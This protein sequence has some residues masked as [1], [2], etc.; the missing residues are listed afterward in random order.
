ME[1]VAVTLWLCLAVCTRGRIT[2]YVVHDGERAEADTP[3]T[4]SAH[5]SPPDPASDRRAPS[6]AAC[7]QASAHAALLALAPVIHYTARVTEGS[8]AQKP[9]QK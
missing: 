8:Q 7:P 9:L 4:G 3:T 1:D 5:R 6:Q 2:L